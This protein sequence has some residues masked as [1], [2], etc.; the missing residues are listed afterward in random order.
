M[1]RVDRGDVKRSAAVWLIG[2][3]ALLALSAPAAGLDPHRLTSQYI[4]DRFG[5]AE[6]LPDGAVWDVTQDRQGYIWAAT[7]NGLVRFDGRQ[8]RVFDMINTP[9]LKTSD[10]RA[11][12]ETPDGSLWIGTYGGGA[13]RLR[14]GQFEPLGT[15][16]G[17]PHPIVYSFHVDRDGGLWMATA[18]GAAYWREGQP[19]QTWTSEDGLAH[20]RVFKILVD[21]RGDAWFA[22]LVNGLS[23]LSNGEWT[24][25][26]RN[27]GLNSNQI[28][29]LFEDSAGVVW[30][31]TYNGDLYRFDD[32]APQPVREREQLPGNG[33]QSMLEDRHGTLWLG[34]YA[35]G[36]LRRAA[37]QADDLPVAALAGAYVFAMTQDVEGALWLATRSGLHRLRDG[38]FLALGEPEGVAAATYVVARDSDGERLWVGTEGSGLF[39]INGQTVSQLTTEQGLASNN[40]S[41][42]APAADGGLWL[43]T[44]GGGLQYLGADGLQTFGRDDGLPSNHVLALLEDR[45]GE[46]LWIGVDGGLVVLGSAGLHSYTAA[47][48][49]PDGLIRQIYQAADGDLWLG[50]NGGGL[51]RFDGETF[52]VL[53]RSD[54]L[55]GN[56]IFAIHEDPGGRL[57]IGAR[58]GGL[59]RIDNGRIARFGP[60]QGLPLTAVH[61]IKEDAQGYLWLSGGTGLVRVR[62]QRLDEL[63]EAGDQAMPLEPWQDIMVF[64]PADGL[65]SSQFIG[66]FQPTA[67][68]DEDGRLWFA[69]GNGLASVR[70]DTLAINRRPPPVHVE[71]V[72]VDGAPLLA[73]PTGYFLQPG[74]DLLEID[75][76]A[77][78]LNAPER[79][80]FRY[81]L[82]GYDRDWQEAGQRRT[83]FYTRL[84]P[85]QYTFRVIASNEDG[86]WNETG[87]SVPLTQVARLDQTLGFRLAMGLLG[88]LLAALV[89]L[90]V[91]RHLRQRERRLE[92]LVRQRTEALEQALEKVEQASK[93]DGLTGV[94]NRG[95]FEQRLAREW[96]QAERDAAPL[97]LIMIDIDHFKALNDLAGHQAGDEA[98]CRVAEALTGVIQRAADLVARYGGEEFVIL[99]P[100]TGREA[101]VALAEQMCQAVREITLSH[102]ALQGRS[103]LTVSAGC[104]AMVP[105]AALATSDLIAQADQALY[106]AKRAGR[107]RVA[108]HQP[109]EGYTAG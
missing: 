108:C 13:Y 64:G 17:L 80:Q 16:Q 5:S 27:S 65:R 31:G 101:C 37:G 20:D 69:S 100:G 91:V 28:H 55:S 40:I 14:D 46:R 90:A 76:T 39:E 102:P 44:F 83:A 26:N 88:M 67:W 1:V 25:W 38:K 79:V 57:W 98:L 54:G 63:A 74:S 36:L 11:L 47:D 89:L 2:L 58:D 49:L 42:L 84:P 12:A 73:S 32:G 4:H 22:T 3:L 24:V 56:I 107:D 87:A 78:A 34:L 35:G 94:A 41:A 105:T 68:Q 6:G 50:S 30:V 61:G 92:Q 9:A 18:G 7:Q 85:G 66:G 70:P 60:E 59:S 51:V 82:E 19:L 43:G 75:Y 99:L 33:V 23:R 15:E 81:R 96:T 53:D 109:D 104:A 71:A 62:R 21:Q 106:A 45:D 97:G 95:Y 8:A 72:R 93:I 103:P 86:V 10:V 52:H 77:L 48:G 29:S